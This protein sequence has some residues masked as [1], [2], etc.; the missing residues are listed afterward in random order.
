MEKVEDPVNFYHSS[1]F[2]FDT[3]H[4]SGEKSQL[5]Y[6]TFLHL[7]LL[8]IRFVASFEENNSAE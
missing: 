2:F 6:S 7:Q 4:S 3:F 5:V 1:D 8:K